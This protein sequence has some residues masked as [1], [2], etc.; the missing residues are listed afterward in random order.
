MYSSAAGDGNRGKLPVS[1]HHAA[2]PTH[3]SYGDDEQE[4]NGGWA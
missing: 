4:E 3:D 1:P 2:P